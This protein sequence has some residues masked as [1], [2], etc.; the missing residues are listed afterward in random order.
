MNYNNGKGKCSSGGQCCKNVS[1]N[2]KKHNDDDPD[3]SE[4]SPFGD[5]VID[6]EDLEPEHAEVAPAVPAPVPAEDVDGNWARPQRERVRALPKP[7][8]P[9]REE[10]ERHQ[11]THIPY[12]VW[13]RHCV[14]C[15]GRNLPHRRVIPLPAENV[16]PVISMDLAHI[17][18]HDADKKLP[19]T[20]A[21]LFA[22]DLKRSHI[23]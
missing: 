18:R 10:R 7:I 6:Q 15:R 17:Q 2:G 13:C 14:A 1:E 21:H 20:F 3:E 16:V 23:S 19:F 8:T 12:A 22:H 11:L 4:L 5:H 9:T